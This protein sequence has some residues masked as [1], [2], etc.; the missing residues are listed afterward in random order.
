MGIQKERKKMKLFAALAIFA[1]SAHGAPEYEVWDE[2]DN[3]CI[4]YVGD[5]SCDRTDVAEK[6]PRQCA[7][8]KIPT[9]KRG[10]F[11]C[12]ALKKN[13]AKEGNSKG[14]NKKKGKASKK[15]RDGKIKCIA[16]DGWV[17]KPKSL[18]CVK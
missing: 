14:S 17:S 8:V 18:K 10:K 1:V 2:Y 4:N 15:A 7:G 12:K 5:T 16:G 9:V 11:V 6:G 13:K 3:V